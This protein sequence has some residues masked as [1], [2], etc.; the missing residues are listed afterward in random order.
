MTKQQ[1]Q[2]LRQPQKP[3]L[4]PRRYRRPHSRQGRTAE[5]Q[6]LQKAR[7]ADRDWRRRMG[8]TPE[9][10]QKVAFGAT[11]RAMITYRSWHRRERKQA[12]RRLHRRTLSREYQTNMMYRQEMTVIA[13]MSDITAVAQAALT[14]LRSIP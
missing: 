10:P 2:N 4:H 11:V 14:T 13:V 12:E 6:K 7:K 8:L 5:T 1:K 9:A 3:Q